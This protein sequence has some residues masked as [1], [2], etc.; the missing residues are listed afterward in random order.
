MI[1]NIILTKISDYGKWDLD[2]FREITHIVQP[3]YASN[4]SQQISEPDYQPEKGPYHDQEDDNR[5]SLNAS[6]FD[7]V[8]TPSYLFLSQN[9]ETGLDS[10]K[11]P[12]TQ[13]SN[14]DSYLQK[15]VMRLATQNARNPAPSLPHEPLSTLDEQQ[16]KQPD[17]DTVRMTLTSRDG[18]VSPKLKLSNVAVHTPLVDEDEEIHLG[19]GTAFDDVDLDIH[20]GVSTIPSSASSTGRIKRKIRTHIAPMAPAKLGGLGPD[21]ENQEYLAKVHNLN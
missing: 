4:S 15:Y 9:G 21:L 12:S 14:S 13:I 6:Q 18:L 17:A 10:K 1:E 11:D 8:I 7:T 20:R 16:R 2:L 19:W 3:L 5:Y